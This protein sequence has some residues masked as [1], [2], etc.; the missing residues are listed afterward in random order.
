MMSEFA[1]VSKARTDRS[2]PWRCSWRALLFFF[3]LALLA[4][5]AGAPVCWCP[6]IL[7]EGGRSGLLPPPL[8]FEVVG[9]RVYCKS[10]GMPASFCLKMVWVA[11]Q[12]AKWKGDVG[13]VIL[14]PFNQFATGE[15]AGCLHPL[16]L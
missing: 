1:E 8:L 3:F 12:N 14:G 15:G 6:V 4:C 2:L 9:P 11:T 5:L 10:R 16:L 13:P 7:N